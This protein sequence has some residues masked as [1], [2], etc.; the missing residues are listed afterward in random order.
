MNFI[1]YFMIMTTILPSQKLKTSMDEK[2]G[3]P[4]MVG[5]AQRSDLTVGY[6]GEWFEEEYIEY[7]GDEELIT[8]SKDFLKEIDIETF[9]G[10]W[11]EDS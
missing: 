5:I 8:A 1:Y 10:T 3:N 6:Y 11:C 4:M 9:L 2:T 7:S